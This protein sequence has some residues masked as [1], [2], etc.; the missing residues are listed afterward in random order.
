VTNAKGPVL[1][2]GAGP[3]GLSL[4]AA[5]VTKGI[6]VELFEAEPALSDEARASTFHPPTLEM[7]AEWGVLDAVLARGKRID[8]LQ[9]WERTTRELVADFD[10]ALLAA[11]TPYPFRFQC[12]QSVVTRELL[13][14][15]L[16]SGLARVHLGQRV[17]GLVDHGA[18]VDAIVES[19]DGPRSV[20]GAYLVGADGS[21]S[22]VR[23]AL[24]V[25][26]EGMTYEDRFLLVAT[27]L[28]PRAFFPDMG[29]VSYVFDPDEWVIVMTLPDVV[30]VVFR[31]NDQEDTSAVRE[32][33]AIRERMARFLGR[34]ADFRIAGASIYAVHQRLAD[35]FRVG[36]ALL[37]GDAAH[38]NTPAGGMGMNS[39]IHDAYH[40]AAALDG[41][42]HA[43]DDAALDAYAEA[44][45]RAA[46][47]DVQRGSDR[48]YKDLAARDRA[49][50]EARNQGLRDAAA[51]P[52]RA[53]AY[54]LRASM[55][56]ARTAATTAR[57]ASAGRAAEP[58]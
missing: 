1:I 33:G 19:A 51:D 21:K 54:L 38:I 29:P 12:P 16:R 22:A 47:S 18:H 55:L 13:P 52:A 17:V 34:A 3:V 28:D 23:Q 49:A 53:R 40:L 20:S 43:G 26:F 48:N 4:A 24:G 39:G 56:E 27:D 36:R 25:G 14:F 10:Y 9:F 7:F 42:L 31:L 35:R 41:A 30:R 46:A 37:A 15:V 11:D 8:R 5:L 50:R 45:H 2:A 32:E 58:S 57:T 6:E 44:R